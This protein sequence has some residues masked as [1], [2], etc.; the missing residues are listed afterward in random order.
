MLHK[1]KALIIDDESLARSIIKE[2][3]NKISELEI[4]G[5]AQNGFEGVKMIQQ[6]SPDLIFLDIQMPKLNG[7]EMLELIDETPA[8]IFT[9][10]YDEY[11]IKAFEINAIDYLLKPFSFER[12]SGAV[13]KVLSRTNDKNEKTNFAKLTSSTI[14]STNRI[15]VKEKS[16]L[17]FIE[18]DEI[19][20]LEAMDDYVRIHTSKGKFLKKQTLANFEKQLPPAIFVRVHRSYLIA[21]KKMKKIYL[22]EKG[23]HEILLQN[24]LR[25]PVSKTGYQLLKNLV[26][27]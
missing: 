11:A 9:T 16:E 5:E 15:I 26:E 17:I 2:Y 24:D 18:L 27:F 23:S 22:L 25:I 19:Y 8:I 4:I 10:A 21:I 12:F 13:N 14:E 6:F 20:F 1:L 3:S 7:F